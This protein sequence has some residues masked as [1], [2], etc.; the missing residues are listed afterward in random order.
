MLRAWFFHVKK[1]PNLPKSWEKS[2]SWKNLSSGYQDSSV[3]K[4]WF[5]T[6][7]SKLATKFATKRGKTSERPRTPISYFVL[8]FFCRLLPRG[9]RDESWR[10]HEIQNSRKVG[11]SWIEKTCKML[12][13]LGRDFWLGNLG[14]EGIKHWNYWEHWKSRKTQ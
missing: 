8:I 10:Q 14:N 11:K 12:G 7:L 4:S 6:C 5:W 9:E 13:V 1:V 3:L 2:W